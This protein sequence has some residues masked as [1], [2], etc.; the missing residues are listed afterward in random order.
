MIWPFVTPAAAWWAW[1]FIPLVLLY[2][3]KLKRP[4]QAIPS[5][6]LWRQVMNDQRVNSPFRRFKR[7]FL[8][9]LQILV[10]G[11]LILAAMQ[12]Y[13]GTGA[14]RAKYLPILI[15]CSASMGALDKPGG[16]TRL[17]VAK[18]EVRKIIENLLS[19]QLMSLII[20]NSTGRRLTDFTNNKKLLNNALDHI[21]VSDVPSRVD[22]ALRLTQ[23]LA[24]T[25]PIERALFLTDGNIPS[26]VDL[27]LPFQVT[28]QLVPTGGANIGITELNAR[29][30]TEHWDVFVR[31]EAAKAGG[32]AAKVEF[33]QDRELLGAERVNL[34]PQESQ[35]L[36]FRAAA[37]KPSQITVRVL[38]ERFDSL[39]CDNVAYLELPVLR[40]MRIY[41]DPD[42]TAFRKA[43]Q[44]IKGVDVLPVPGTN[45][46]RLVRGYDVVI[47]ENVGETV[48]Q[49]PVTMIVGQV[50]PEASQLTKIETDFVKVVDWQRNAP[51]LRHVQLAD[52]QMSD[53]PVSAANVED[54]DYEQLGYEILAHAARGP[55]ILH[56][57]R[58]GQQ[59][60]W[61]LFHPNRS[62]LPY[63]VGFPILVSNLVQ[64]AMQQAGLA[65][66][67][68]QSTGVLP[69]RS[70]QPST[71]HTIISPDGLQQ[72]ITTS[73][74][75]Q[76]GG[77]SAPRVGIYVIQR[78]L[79]IVSR[80][81]ASLL[82]A[83]ETSLQFVDTIQFRE[84]SIA[85][86]ET[87]Q[88]T[89]KPL[90]TE[91]AIAG[92]LFLALEWWYFQRR[93]GGW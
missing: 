59:S 25:Y 14:S 52:V 72:E 6:A 26:S 39:A 63:R 93:P 71:S 23:A 34:D 50:P 27:E 15:D 53:N 12:P 83:D 66:V 84:I 49:A 76:L 78:G 8:L 46:P 75:G 30:G 5:L 21:V 65:E 9:L 57:D 31:L 85:G 91:F 56:K 73:S 88:A 32:G 2:F 4:V 36:V 80:T 37:G 10:L 13:W 48:P 62:T 17:D 19:D 38:A 22:D 54:R 67:R 44:P 16:R 86:S 70:A 35:R 41:V 55:L 24:R 40:S 79:A 58:E 3:L 68:S 43:L 74:D 45:K 33:Y 90:W 28:L 42:L 11:C 7:N 87:R 29:R 60:F 61:L 82:Q 47:S 92:M 51:L 89:D 77:I 1:L 20:V 81:S 69:P 18:A 64:I